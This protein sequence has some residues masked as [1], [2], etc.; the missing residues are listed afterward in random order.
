M[1]TVVIARPAS[2]PVVAQIENT[3][4][5]MQA[6]VGGYVECLHMEGL[7]LWINEEGLAEGLPFN[8]E[9]DGVTLVGNVLVAG[10]T[11]DGD[12]RSL[13]PGEVE[14]ALALLTPPLAAAHA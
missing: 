12:T 7:D 4:A 1:M 9:V 11:P 3:L 14:Q 10:V 2:R 8:I 5:A 6:V 13:T